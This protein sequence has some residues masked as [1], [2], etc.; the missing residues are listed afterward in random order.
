MF[1]VINIYSID[2]QYCLW[3]L[4]LLSGKVNLCA[5]CVCARCALARVLIFQH[6]FAIPLSAPYID[7]MLWDCT[8]RESQGWL[9]TIRSLSIS[10]IKRSQW[11][12][13]TPVWKVELIYRGRGLCQCVCET[14]NGRMV[15]L[16]QCR[17]SNRTTGRRFWMMKRKSQGLEALKWIGASAQTREP[18]GVCCKCTTFVSQG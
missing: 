2:W 4:F 8:F 5:A 10:K 7:V 1:S 14:M 13:E 15:R 9:L 11:L 18:D 16:G 6:L 12:T 17:M 3:F